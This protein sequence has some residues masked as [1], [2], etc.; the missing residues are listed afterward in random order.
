MGQDEGHAV[1]E[2]RVHVGEVVSAVTRGHG[3]DLGALGK[4][5]GVGLE[6][7]AGVSIEGDLD[8]ELVIGVDGVLGARSV[9]IV[10]EALSGVVVAGATGVAGAVVALGIGGVALVGGGGPDPLVGLHDVELRAPSSIDLVGIAVS[11]TV[12]VSPDVAVPVLGGGQD[13]VEGRDAAALLVA[14]VDVVLNNT[15]KKVGS[16]V[17]RVAGVEVVGIEDVSTVV[18]LDGPVVAGGATRADVL[19]QGDA[20]LNDLDGSEAVGDLVLEGPE[21]V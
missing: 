17:L 8:V 21:L 16:V 12:G 4:G 5:G 3:E 2:V 13:G 7:A 20:I 18:L 9:D 1:A 14:E 6:A 11:K 15:T 19:G 10:V